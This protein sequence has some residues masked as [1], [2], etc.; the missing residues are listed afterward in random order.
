MLAGVR[1]PCTDCGEQVSA[2]DDRHAC[3]EARREQYRALT[4]SWLCGMLAAHR[5]AV[6]D[7]H[8]AAFCTLLQFLVLEEPRDR[9]R[10]LEMCFLT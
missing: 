8:Q 4:R 6:V 1:V 9:F 7:Q 3:D 10:I 5:I 2:Y